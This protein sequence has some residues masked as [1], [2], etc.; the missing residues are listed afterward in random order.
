[1]FN[2]EGEDY[3]VSKEGY[4]IS[5]YNFVKNRHT[6]NYT[7]L[8]CLYSFNPHTYVFPKGY[9]DML[10]A[11]YPSAWVHLCNGGKVGNFKFRNIIEKNFSHIRE[12]KVW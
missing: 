9:R 1:M 12:D 6:P 11:F 10:R 5:T 7:P 3:L 2:K 8:Q 4:T